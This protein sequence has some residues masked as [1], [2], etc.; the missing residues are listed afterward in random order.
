MHQLG[1]PSNLQFLKSAVGPVTEQ[2]ELEGDGLQV[3]MGQRFGLFRG[4]RVASLGAHKVLSAK[5]LSLGIRIWLS[6]K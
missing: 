5:Q 6:G 3:E 4:Q 1:L 2:L